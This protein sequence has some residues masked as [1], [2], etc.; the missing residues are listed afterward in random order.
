M[1]KIIFILLSVISITT[2]SQTAKLGLLLAPNT[3]QINVIG[4]GDTAITI[5]R[6]LLAK[7]VHFNG[8]DSSVDISFTPFRNVKEYRKASAFTVT[9]VN[10]GK[11]FYKV[12]AA[13][14]SDYDSY[15]LQQAKAYYVS[16]GYFVNIQ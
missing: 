12:P 14:L 2:Y 11:Q 4:A 9:D 16:L 15:A 7:E 3:T 1:K 8:I 13:N 5:A 6:L 10:T